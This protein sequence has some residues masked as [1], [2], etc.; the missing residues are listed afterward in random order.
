[1]R[2]RLESSFVTKKFTNLTVIVQVVVW[3]ARKSGEDN[4]E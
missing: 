3:I 4:P 1:M 2:T